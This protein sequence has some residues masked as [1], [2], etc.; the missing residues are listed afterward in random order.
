MFTLY[1]IPPNGVL[2][3]YATCGRITDESAEHGDYAEN[4]W[5]NSLDSREI[6]ESRNDVKPVYEIPVSEFFNDIARHKE[7]FTEIDSILGYL[8]AD[9]KYSEGSTVYATD[10]TPDMMTGDYYGYA[11]HAHV[12]HLTPDG[13]VESD[14]NILER[15]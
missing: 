11:I 10:A 13:Y 5:V 8:G 15:R 12:K 6:Y 4:G 1:N 7:V 9:E 3:I 2:R 14:V